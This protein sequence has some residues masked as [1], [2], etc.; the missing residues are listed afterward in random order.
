MLLSVRKSAV[1]LNVVI[2]VLAVL[3]VSG[4]PRS[5]SAS[6]ITLTSATTS[7]SNAS[8]TLAKVGDTVSFQLNLSGTPWQAPTIN[9]LNMGTTSFSGSG[10]AWT[11]STTTTSAW[12]NGAVTF[13]AAFGGTTG[14]EATTTISQSNLTGANVVF[15]KSIPS[16][17]T[18][19]V[20]SSNSSTTLAKIGDTIT[21]TFLGSE[22]LK[23]PTVTIAGHTATVLATTTPASFWMAST[24]IQSGDTSGVLTFSIAAPVDTAGNASSTAQTTLTSGAN[25]TVYGSKPTVSVQGTNPDT[26]YSSATASYTDAGATAT[27]A[28]GATLSTATSGSVN[29]AAPGTYT[30]TYSAT[31][32]AGNVNSASRSVTVN[33]QPGN[34]PVAI[35]VYT[36]PTIIVPQFPAST[37]SVAAPAAQSV[38]LGLL[39]A[40]VQTL[41]AQIAALQSAGSHSTF[42]RNLMRGSKGT[43]VKSLQMYL[44]TH[45][46]VVAMNGPGSTGNETMT[47]GN[48]TKKALIKMQKAVGIAPASGYFGPKTRAYIAKNP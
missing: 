9:I 25:V 42:S 11:Y 41:L 34:G 36:P 33:T 29:R 20:S 44:N 1:L 37:T 26:V 40:Q 43:D 5:A 39:Q 8:T 23:T 19:T 18:A 17:V 46:Y 47:F 4:A 31:D 32:A 2:A 16:I 35:S 28:L 24:T 27:D 14:A 38:Q 15:D 13:F 30:L 7:S 6:V 21:L 48:A 12:S 10:A 22:N 45:G 3:V